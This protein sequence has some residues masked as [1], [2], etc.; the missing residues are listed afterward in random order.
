MDRLDPIDNYETHDSWVA[1]MLQFN[2]KGIPDKTLYDMEYTIPFRQIVKKNTL[3]FIA[4][5]VK[6]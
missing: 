2:C 3:I 1:T 5:Y 4:K 6:N